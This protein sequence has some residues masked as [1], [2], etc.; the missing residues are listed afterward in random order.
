MVSLREAGKERKK[1][2]CQVAKN[3]EKKEKKQVCVIFLNE[4]VQRRGSHQERKESGS[5]RYS[6]KRKFRTPVNPISVKVDEH[7]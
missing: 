2:D 5:R 1:R 7:V 6:W 3:W 4:K